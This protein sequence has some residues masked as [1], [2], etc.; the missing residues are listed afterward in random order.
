[1]T[2]PPRPP[3]ADETPPAADVVP[4]AKAASARSEWQV[5]RELLPFLKPFTGRI[6]LALALVVVAKLSNLAVPLVLKQLVDSLGV[7][8]LIAW[9]EK[10]FDLRIP[11]ED[12]TIDN[13]ETI[14]A[15]D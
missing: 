2:N 7:M 11:P 14:D 13:F 10:R 1:M 3:A 9:I 6:A 4:V 8:R 12:V 15:I 5:L